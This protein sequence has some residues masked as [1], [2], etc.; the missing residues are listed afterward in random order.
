MLTQELYQK[1]VTLLKNLIATPSFSKEEDKTAAIIAAF[2][3]EQGVEV[4]QQQNNVWAFNKHYNPALPTLLLNSH[5]DTVKPNASYTRDPFEP[6]IEDGKL[7]GL[8]S[9]DAGGCL[10][11][12]ISTFLWF[13]ERKNL[14]YNLVLA[15]TAEEE[16]SGRNGIELIL[17]ELGQLEAAIVGEPTEMHLAVAEKGLLVLDCVAKGK[18]GHAAREEGVNAIYE[19]LSDIQWFQ[20]YRFPKESEHLGPVKMSVTMVQAGTQHNVVPDRCQ[21]TVD[22]RLTDAYTMGEVLD[23]IQQQ[24]KAEVTPRST[25]L[26]PSSIPM[27]HPLVQAGL[28]MGRKTYGSPTTSDQALLPIPSLKMGPGYSGRSHMAD[29]YIYLHEIEEGIKL[30][31]ELLEQ[32]L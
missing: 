5:H 19:A 11:S 20:N 31:I 23:T 4:Q 12:L 32:V 17:P 24:V 28:K 25:R 22:V 15:A 8:G 9:N 2:L 21:F 14:Q 30:Y 10:V 6:K 13:Y 18:A 27:A 7:F 16:I 29:E 1:A 3:K 26:K